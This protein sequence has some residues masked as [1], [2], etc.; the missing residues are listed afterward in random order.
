MKLLNGDCRK[1]VLE[2]AKASSSGQVDAIITDPPYEIGIGGHAWD[3]SGVAHDPATWE[4]F[5]EL[6]KPGGYLL[7]FGA[8]RNHHRM[9]CAIEDAG[10]EIQD[11]IPWLYAQGYPKG[12]GLLKPANEPIVVA[13]NGG[14]PGLDTDTRTDWRWPSNVAVD[15]HVAEFLADRADAPP[16]AFIAKPSPGERRLGAIDGYH[17]T[18]KPLKLMRWLVRLTT[19][20]GETVLDPFMGSGTTIAAAI[21]EARDAIGVELEPD[22]LRHAEIRIA[23]LTAP[24]TRGARA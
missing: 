10:Y 21:I 17:P 5:R 8:T 20:P 16:F 1:L 7:A 2:I 14:P 12:K 23:D 19:V 4:S 22:S 3:S 18:I 15:E 9:T 11:E 6:L 13:R 24:W